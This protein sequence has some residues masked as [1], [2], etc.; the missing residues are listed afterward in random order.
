MTDA[1]IAAARALIAKASTG[2][3]HWVVNVPDGDRTV[4]TQ[5]RAMFDL[6]PAAPVAEC[7]GVATP[8]DGLPVESL[9]GGEALYLCITGNG[10]NSA[11]NAR[12]IVGSFDPIA[13]WSA[14]LDE[15]ER[16]RAQARLRS[17][18]RRG[19]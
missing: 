17:V 6:E 10:P 9:D 4:E 15:I 19:A 13:G 16:L 2:P 18:P 14:A 8:V 11:A 7:H 1:D 12:Y 3:K 5:L